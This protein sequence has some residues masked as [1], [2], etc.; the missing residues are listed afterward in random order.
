MFSAIVV[1]IPESMAENHVASEASQL[2]RVWIGGRRE[3]ESPKN[4]PGVL[5]QM[6]I[7]AV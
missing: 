7:D 4:Q 2:P 5:G 6:T 1:A 3:T